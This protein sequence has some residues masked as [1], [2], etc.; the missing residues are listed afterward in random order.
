[1]GVPELDDLTIG[2]LVMGGGIETTSHKYGLFQSI[3]KAY[4]L[5]LSDGSVIWC[6][7]DNN[8]EVFSSIPFS[9]GTFG[10][11]TAVDI[12]IVP[13]KPFL[14]HTYHPTN[15]LKE[16]VDLLEKFSNDPEIDTVEGIV[17]TE[18]QSV[19]MSGRFVQE[20][21]DN[22]EVNRIG[23]WYKPWFY[24]HVESF[25]TKRK[26]ENVKEDEFTE[27]IPTI[28]Y[29]HRHNRAYFW[30]I[31][32]QLSCV[33]DLW[34]RY[35][36][37]WT[38]PPKFSLLK[39]LRSTME[40]GA[41]KGPTDFCLQ[42]YGIEISKLESLIKFTIQ[43]TEVFPIWLCPA[44][45]I[46]PKEIQHLTVCPSDALYFDVGIYGHS[47]KKGFHKVECQKRIEK[48]LLQNEGFVALYGE[49]ELTKEQF[50]EMFEDARNHYDRLRKKYDCEDAF[51]HVYNKIS[52]LGKIK[53]GSLFII[54]LL[55]YII[56]VCLTLIITSWRINCILE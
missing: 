35:L 49:T 48:W 26:Q 51:P 34:F 44:R 41:D 46:S 36:L 31:K 3:C 21:T 20:T 5:V 29:F 50:Y 32:N 53:N 1:M 14:K 43:E 13:Y 56:V 25:L 45:K 12:D 11:L 15:S 42:D 7:K 2:G 9:Y 52:R 27:Y 8:N 10:F 54:L 16:A 30:L 47:P 23:L 55:D 22:H 24:T 39:F 18:T 19:V 17:Y 4:E 6:D 33:N 28:D 40:G 37:G 38:M